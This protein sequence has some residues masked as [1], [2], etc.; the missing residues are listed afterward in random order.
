[1]GD[2]ARLREAI[3]NTFERANLPDMTDQERIRTLTFVVV[4]AGPTGVE[5]TAELKDF[6]E[7]DCPR[8]YPHLLPFIR[9][10]VLEA[11][12]RVLMQFEQGLQAEAVKDLE[13]PGSEAAVGLGLHQDYVKVLLK[14]SV[15]EVTARDMTLNDGTVIPYGVAVWAAGMYICIYACFD[16]S[17]VSFDV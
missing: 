17:Q 7:Q 6:I 16:V 8:F 13:M 10:K 4:G 9:I 1:V 11:S 3:G 2:A 12:D 5:L 15:K 14:S